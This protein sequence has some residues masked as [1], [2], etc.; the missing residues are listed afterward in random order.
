MHDFV[1][2][3]INRNFYAP[4]ASS[5]ELPE[6]REYS[7]FIHAKFENCALTVVL[8]YPKSYNSL[9]SIKSAYAEPKTKGG[10][11]EN[12]FVQMLAYICGINKLKWPR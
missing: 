5:V 4:I 2:F 12:T 9:R 7:N 10:K 8:C 6:S 11:K 3:N 1:V